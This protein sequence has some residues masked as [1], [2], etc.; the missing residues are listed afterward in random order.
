MPQKIQKNTEVQDDKKNAVL[1]S[2][3]DAENAKIFFFAETAKWL[4]M[5]QICSFPFYYYVLL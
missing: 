4:K 2:K 5:C 3:A 1:I